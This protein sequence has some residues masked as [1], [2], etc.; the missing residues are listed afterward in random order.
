MVR[1]MKSQ[2]GGG[3]YLLLQPGS[4]S[5]LYIASHTCMQVSLTQAHEAQ[6]RI[7]ARLHRQQP[8]AVCEAS[9]AALPAQTTP[10]PMPL[11]KT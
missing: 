9:A 8:A 1:I 10:G 11:P 4:D 3:A 7:H 6:C 5:M 2:D